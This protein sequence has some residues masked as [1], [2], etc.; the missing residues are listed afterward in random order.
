MGLVGVGG[1]ITSWLLRMWLHSSMAWVVIHHFNN[2][3]EGSDLLIW[4]ALVLFLHLVNLI[5]AELLDLMVLARSTHWWRGH[6]AKLISDLSSSD[7][8]SIRPCILSVYSGWWILFRLGSTSGRN[9][10]LDQVRITTYLI[11]T[12]RCG[13]LVFQWK[14]KFRHQSWLL[15]SFLLHLRLRRRFVGNLFLSRIF[16]GLTLA[17]SKQTIGIWHSIENL[18]RWSLIITV[19][20]CKRMR[21]STTWIS[22]SNK[23]I[24]RVIELLNSMWVISLISVRYWGLTVL[25]LAFYFRLWIWNTSHILCLNWIWTVVWHPFTTHGS[26]TCSQMTSTTRRLCWGI[27]ITSR[28]HKL[29]HRATILQVRILW[30][31]YL[32]QLRLILCGPSCTVHSR[33]LPFVRVLRC[34]RGMRI[35]Y[36]TIRVF[37]RSHLINAIWASLTYVSI[38]SSWVSWLYTLCLL[39]E[40]LRKIHSF[41]KDDIVL[42][43]LD[44]SSLICFV[45]LSTLFHFQIHLFLPIKLLCSIALLSSAHFLNLGFLLLLILIQSITLIFSVLFHNRTRSRYQLIVK[46][47]IC[48]VRWCKIGSLRVLNHGK[49]LVKIHLLFNMIRVG[50]PLAHFEWLAQLTR[51]LWRLSDCRLNYIFSV[52]NIGCLGARM[53]F[54]AYKGLLTTDCPLTVCKLYLI[55]ISTM[56]D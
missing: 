8:L 55:L 49:E 41:R 10:W 50:S 48:L 15:V 39:G 18:S 5:L 47:A 53:R 42:I 1:L 6:E 27:L 54:L 35:V 45:P 12:S 31:V 19:W 14:R 16:N 28:L 36:L 25:L 9:H 24:G 3:F 44:A 17:L 56:L 38:L 22:H 43:K 32:V 52:L 13:F 11:C 21:L 37:S 34:M 40:E 4:I 26:I 46:R 33:F 20:T 2:L 23:L 51:L 29:L 7:S 30:G